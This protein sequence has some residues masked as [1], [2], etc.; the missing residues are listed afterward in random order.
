MTATHPTA[1]QGTAPQPTGTQ[2]ERA[3]L[4]ATAADDPDGRLSAVMAL[5]DATR[6]LMHAAPLTQAD[7]DAIR[8]AAAAVADVVA[9]LGEPGDQLTRV[10]YDAAA[11]ERVR[12]G[13]LWMM[14]PCN[15][16]TVP[17]EYAV[18]GRRAYADLEPGPLLEGPPGLLHGGFAAHLLDA[19]IGGLVHVQGTPAYTVSLDLTFRGP[20]E[21]SAPMRV[22]AEMGE[23]DGRKI[24]AHGWISQAGRRTVE[25]EALFVVPPAGTPPIE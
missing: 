18:D 1:T 24:R 12:A 9:D 22:E 4:P 17:M 6:R 15:P 11:V 25:A 20:T 10:A 2:A 19:L 8:A 14:A 5:V 16:M 13:G 21:L 23:V 7:P 3:Y